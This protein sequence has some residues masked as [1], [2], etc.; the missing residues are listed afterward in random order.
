MT[1]LSLPT[2]AQDKPNARLAGS[3]TF[4]AELDELRP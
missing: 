1:T 3:H 4:A 2:Q